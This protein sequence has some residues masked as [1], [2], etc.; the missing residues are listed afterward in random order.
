MI[1]PAAPTTLVVNGAIR[2][3]AQGP[4]RSM[5]FVLRDELGLTG[6]KPGCGE[7]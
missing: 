4:D 6:A 7:G 2:P 1:D 3:V 5:L